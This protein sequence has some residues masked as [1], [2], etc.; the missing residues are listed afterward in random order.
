MC[1]CLPAATG[2][3]AVEWIRIVLG[4]CVYGTAGII[5]VVLGLSSIAFWAFAR[6]FFGFTV[7]QSTILIYAL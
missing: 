3:P 6:E 4:D 7:V 5:S 1:V 2:Q